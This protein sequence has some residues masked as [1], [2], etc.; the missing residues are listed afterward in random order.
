[1][2]KVRPIFA[3]RIFVVRLPEEDG[4][5]PFTS[6]SCDGL[7][8]GRRNN[9]R[10]YPLMDMIR[11]RV[12]PAH[13]CPLSSVCVHTERPTPQQKAGTIPPSRRLTWTI[14]LIHTT[15]SIFGGCTVCENLNSPVAQATQPN[16]PSH[17]NV[18]EMYEEALLFTSMH[19]TPQN[20]GNCLT[21]GL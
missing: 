9:A 21:S 6:N 8:L 5:V 10:A 7:G 1:M 15:A 19:E 2:L 17:D 20:L 11:R 13:Q 16:G 4:T 12:A 14:N 3:N 18:V